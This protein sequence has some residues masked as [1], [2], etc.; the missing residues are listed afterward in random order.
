MKEPFSMDP[1]RVVLSLQGRDQGRYFLI[2]ENRGDGFVLIADG[3]T[4]R[5]ENP[6]IK[7]CKHLRAKPVLLDLD[8]LRPE[9]G[10]L[11]DSDLRKALENSGFAEKRS[12]CKGSG[13]KRARED[14]GFTADIKGD[15]EDRVAQIAHEKEG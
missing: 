11:Q 2:L 13:A 10:R 4:R 14:G 12:L 6:K 15:A 5:L 7:K 8:T 3:D 1:G 9:G